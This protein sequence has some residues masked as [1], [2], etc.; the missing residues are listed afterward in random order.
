MQGNQV[1]FA[2]G[3][4]RLRN[5]V[6]EDI[7]RYIRWNTEE[8]EWQRWDAPWEKKEND[9][10][11]LRQLIVRILDRPK[12][13]IWMRLQLCLADGQHLGAVSTYCING[14][15]QFRAVGIFIPEKEYWGQGIGYEALSIWIAYLFAVT[16]N[17]SL[18]C[19]TWSGNTRMVRLA[20]KCGFKEIQR[21]KN[22]REVRGQLYDGLRFV[23]DRPT[24][25]TERNELFLNIVEQMNK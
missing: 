18:Y 22:S 17:D 23:L 2:F 11:K 5:V 3:R 19:E 15:E 9:P 14:D 7:E 24:F 10:E 13:E 21:K 4:V 6:T 8:I 20:E 12:P 1:E 25:L 16:G